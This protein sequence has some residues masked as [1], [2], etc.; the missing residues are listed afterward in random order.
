MADILIRPARIGDAE[1]MIDVLN[2]I[3]RAGGTTAMETELSLE[4][5]RAFIAGLGPREGCHV[6][7]E[8]RRDEILGFQS[9]A[10]HHALPRDVADIATFVRIGEKGRGVGRSLSEASFRAAFADGYAAIN[11]TIR[12]D[13]FEGLAFYTRM[14]FRDASITRARPLG[15]GKKVDRISKRRLLP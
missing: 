4:E 15:S 11:A 12:A 3:I 2:P 13:N 7:I 9:Y 10:F 1:G 6:A 14:G 8:A 5:Q